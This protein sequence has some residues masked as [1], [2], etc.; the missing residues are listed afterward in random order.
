V[1]DGTGGQA[2]GGNPVAAFSICPGR[3]EGVGR[4]GMTINFLPERGDQDRLLQHAE[5]LFR[6]IAEEVYGALM[7]VQAGDLAETKASAQAAKELRDTFRT[8]M[9]EGTRVAKLRKQVVGVVG[10]Q[11]L[12]F[13]AARDEVGRRLARLRDAGG[14]G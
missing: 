9:D 1:H 5:D 6:S 3:S 8:L 13:D 10:G 14:G 4:R 7:R 2:A 11:E 12:D